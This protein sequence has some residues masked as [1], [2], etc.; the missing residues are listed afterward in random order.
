MRTR[1]SLSPEFRYVR[2][3]A[4]ARRSSGVCRRVKNRPNDAELSPTEANT[5]LAGQREGSNSLAIEQNTAHHQLNRLLAEIG[6]KRNAAR[7]GDESAEAWVVGLNHWIR[8]Y[9]MGELATDPTITYDLVPLL[10]D[11]SAVLEFEKGYRC[12]A[13]VSAVGTA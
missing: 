10:K 8:Q 4:M 6:A 5:P 2:G 9:K 12:A 13:A 11:Y 1:R 7:R 3:G